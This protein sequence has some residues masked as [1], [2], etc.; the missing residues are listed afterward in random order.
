M[1]TDKLISPNLRC[2]I[3]F[4]LTV[5]PNGFLHSKFILDF[6][7]IHVKVSRNFDYS[8]TLLVIFTIESVHCDCEKFVQGL[9]LFKD[10]WKA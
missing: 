6:H 4:H 10:V 3:H 8:R 9:G 7:V 1:S 5:G 2:I